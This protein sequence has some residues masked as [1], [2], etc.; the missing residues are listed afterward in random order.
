LVPWVQI[1]RWQEMKKWILVIVIL[2]IATVCSSGAI[3]TNVIK[4]PQSIRKYL[5]LGERYGK[6]SISY[7]SA[8]DAEV[9]FDENNQDL[10]SEGE[11]KESNPSISLTRRDRIFMLLVFIGS[12]VAAV[13]S[14][15]SMVIKTK[16]SNQEGGNY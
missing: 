2:A 10:M 8:A 11:K 7:A 13:A 3:K 12:T 9:G 6:G 5:D 14:I 16:R 15:I 4:W 1:E